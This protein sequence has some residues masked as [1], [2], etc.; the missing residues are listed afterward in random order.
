MTSDGYGDKRRIIFKGPMNFR[1]LGGYKTK[2]GRVIKWRRV[3]RS[4][5][6]HTMTPEDVIYALDSLRIASVIDLRGEDEIKRMGKSP[7]TND[8]ARYYHL[9]FLNA[10]IPPAQHDPRVAPDMA[11]HYGHIM[12]GAS[13]NIASAVKY[14]ATDEE[15]PAVFHCY[16]GKDRTGTLAAVILGSLGVSEEDIIEDY[17]ISEGY[18]QP[19]FARAETNKEMGTTAVSAG[20][21]SSNPE[22]MERLLKW[23][24][25]K[26][27]DM[28]SY[29]QSIGVPPATLD[30]LRDLMLEKPSA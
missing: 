17:A 5:S 27:R 16:G 6:H 12:V 7:L 26:Y 3:F 23:V 10:K 22:T 30:R 8:K 24:R 25:M 13:E 29:L 28:P 2:D 15:H 21:L 19:L 1:D 20:L 11:R 4:D 14:L 18:L 9:P